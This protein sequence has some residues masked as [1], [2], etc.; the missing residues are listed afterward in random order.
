MGV[1]RE[2]AEKAPKPGVGTQMGV[3]GTEFRG[4]SRGSLHWLG[5]LQGMCPLKRHCVLRESAQCYKQTQ[6]PLVALA[7]A[8]GMTLGW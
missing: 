1:C 8:S 5:D 4:Q 6:R 7:P 2:P 3:V